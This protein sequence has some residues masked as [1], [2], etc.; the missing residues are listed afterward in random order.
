MDKMEGQG[1]DAGRSFLEP[2][3]SPGGLPSYQERQEN[4]HAPVDHGEMRGNRVR[5]RLDGTV[6]WDWAG[7]GLEPWTERGLD[8]TGLACGLRAGPWCA[9]AG[10]L[11]W[12]Q[13]DGRS[14]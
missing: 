2:I 7:L 11:V 5:G 6:R 3:D 9:G 10:S 8:W 1:D 4:S 14:G 12:C 13:V